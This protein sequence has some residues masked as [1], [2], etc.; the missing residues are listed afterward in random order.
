MPEVPAI[1]HEPA[2][3]PMP[4]TPQ[5]QPDAT[6][7][8]PAPMVA[9]SL[10]SMAALDNTSKLRIG[11]T[12]SFRIIEDRDAPVTRLVTDSGEIEF[13][14]VGRVKAQD[15]TCRE[16]AYELKK[17]LEI[18]YYEKATVII[19]IDH[20]A[21]ESTPHDYVWLI[22]ETRAVGPQQISPSQPMTLSQIIL[23]AGGFGAY[24]DERH[25]RLVHYSPTTPAQ[26]RGNSKAPIVD[27]KD[28]SATPAV[29]ADS[30][31]SS[32]AK[33]PISEQMVD[34]K[35]VLEGKST[36]DPIVS[37]GDKII[38]KKRFINF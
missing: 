3:T 18:H 5:D 35:A 31:D 6:P 13:P 2:P 1:N 29:S 8:E 36:V 10:S 17:T 21:N 7:Q 19:G 16:L 15:K 28:G 20:M 9:A 30:T 25:V 38:V 24:A 26:A 34:V 33:N 27:P 11:D 12:I 23:K 4:V 14:Y 22:G 37:P 32:S